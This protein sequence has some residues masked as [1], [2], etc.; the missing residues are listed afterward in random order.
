MSKLAPN[1]T[2]FGTEVMIARSGEKG[3]VTAFARHQRTR[4]VQYF[5]EYTNAMGVAS[6]EWFHE[7]QLSV[8]S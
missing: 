7:D 3:V 4:P 2:V 8:V 1:K 5:V 6:E